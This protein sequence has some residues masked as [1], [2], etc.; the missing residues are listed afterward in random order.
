MSLPE[1]FEIFSCAQ[2]DLEDGGSQEGNEVSTC[3]KNGKTCKSCYTCAYKVLHKYSV[4]NAAYS[5]VYTVYHFLLTLAVTQV[6]CERSFSKLIKTRLRSSLSQENFGS[7]LLMSV[8]GDVLS[9]V[10][11]DKIVDKLASTFKELKRLLII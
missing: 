7:L 4:N 6:E 9:K 11:L 8:E 2:E 1:E 5:E 3:K 10:S